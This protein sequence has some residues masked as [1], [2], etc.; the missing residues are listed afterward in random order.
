[1]FKVIVRNRTDTLGYVEIVTFAEAHLS[2]DAVLGR[3][4]MALYEWLADSGQQAATPG[5][6]S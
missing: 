3:F 2:Q 1:M 4:E 5:E 6:S